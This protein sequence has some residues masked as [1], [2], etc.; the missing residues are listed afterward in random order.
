MTINVSDRVLAPWR[1]KR[2]IESVQGAGG[3]K[4]Q[5]MN[6]IWYLRKQRSCRPSRRDRAP[7]TA[8]KVATCLCVTPEPLTAAEKSASV[9][10]SPSCKIYNANQF[11]CFRNVTPQ[12]LLGPRPRRHS[13]T[14][15]LYPVCKLLARRGARR[16]WSAGARRPRFCVFFSM[17]FWSGF[18][19]LA[20]PV[21]ACGR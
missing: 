8:T 21:L 6:D 12:A 14:T 18:P 11:A 3:R 7:K 13:Q 4:S 1:T 9:R 20:S 17:F 16:V 10:S 2:F 19:F 15:G 5:E